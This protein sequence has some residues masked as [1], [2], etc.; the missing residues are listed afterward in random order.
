MLFYIY[1]HFEQ[2]SKITHEFLGECTLFKKV[3]SGGIKLCCASFLKGCLIASQCSLRLWIY[4]IIYQNDE[5][6]CILLFFQFYAFHGLCLYHMQQFHAGKGGKFVIIKEFAPF[7]KKKIK[8][9]FT[10]DSNK[11]IRLYFIGMAQI[12]K[13]QFYYNFLVYN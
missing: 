3:H 4:F 7:F 10:F 11:Q 6:L 2:Q 1:Y 9:V 13:L 5:S 12:Y 8:D